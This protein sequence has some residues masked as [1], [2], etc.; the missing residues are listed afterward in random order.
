MKASTETARGIERLKARKLELFQEYK[1]CYIS[2]DMY[3]DKKVAI[4]EQVTSLEKALIAEQKPQLSTKGL[5]K[6]IVEAH[7]E[8]IVVDCLGFFEVIYKS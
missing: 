5:T 1:E 3:L 8:K 7:V 4:D 2:R 6:E